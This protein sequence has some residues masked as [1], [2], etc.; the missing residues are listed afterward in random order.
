MNRFPRT[1]ATSGGVVTDYVG[2]SVQH[3]RARKIRPKRKRGYPGFRIRMMD[4]YVEQ[5]RA[6]V[7]C[8][9]V[10]VSQFVYHALLTA[11]GE[12]AAKIGMAPCD[13]ARLRK[14]ARAEIRRQ[15][16]LARIVNMVLEPER[17]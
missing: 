6:A 17:N 10:G 1:S 4:C 5:I 15:Y 16:R 7:E 8:T 11:L 2:T 3:G 13:I 14:R 9:G 12:T